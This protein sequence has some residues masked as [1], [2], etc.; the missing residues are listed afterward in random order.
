MCRRIGVFIAC[1]ERTSPNMNV[2]SW[3]EKMIVR[4][5]QKRTSLANCIARNVVQGNTTSQRTKRNWKHLDQLVKR[6]I[7]WRY[8]E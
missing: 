8:E 5:T 1:L 7:T 4:A 2:D 3:F 6:I